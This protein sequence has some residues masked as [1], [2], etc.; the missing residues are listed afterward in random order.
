MDKGS[1]LW[2]D[3]MPR[4]DPGRCRH[5]P[6]CPPVAVCSA[7]AFRRDGPDSVPY[8]DESFCFGCYTCAEAC[9]H[10]AIVLPRRR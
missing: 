2:D 4:V 10:G 5:C 7:Q 6:D 3:I 8:A 1:G 9:P